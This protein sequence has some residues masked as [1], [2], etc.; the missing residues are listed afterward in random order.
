MSGYEVTRDG[1]VFSVTSNWRGYGRREMAQTLTEYGYMSVRLTVNGRRK[2][3]TVHRLVAESFLRK[4]A[5]G[6]QIR[7]LDGNRL[8]NKSSNLKWGTAKDNARDR[9]RHGRTSSGPSHGRAISIGHTMS[10][11][12]KARA[13]LAKVTGEEK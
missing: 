13:A 5:K 8:N 11:I 9:Q 1:R 4:P 6:E 3:V 10:R 2:R 7:H 12:T